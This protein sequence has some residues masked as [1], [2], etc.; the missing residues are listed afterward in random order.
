MVYV[1]R[2]ARAIGAKVTNPGATPR[3]RSNIAKFWAGLK[4]EGRKGPAPLQGAN[5]SR[6]HDTQGVA[7]G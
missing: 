2:R 7:L 6:D 4:P 3:G 5:Q 1:K